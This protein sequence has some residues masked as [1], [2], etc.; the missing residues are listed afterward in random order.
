MDIGLVHVQI[1]WLRIRLSP[2]LL[3][4]ALFTLILDVMGQKGK[5]W[6][7][8]FGKSLSRFGC[9]K[10]LAL[11]LCSASLISDFC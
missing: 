11:N 9:L 7:L 5:I 6:I 10:S 4:R 1:V 2:P 3:R 8:R